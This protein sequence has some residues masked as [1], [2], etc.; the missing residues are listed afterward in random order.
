MI[1]NNSPKSPFMGFEFTTSSDSK[2]LRH[3]QSMKPN[4]QHDRL[5]EP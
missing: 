2:C 5:F 4:L 3:I 1:G